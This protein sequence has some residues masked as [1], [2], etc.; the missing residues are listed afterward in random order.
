MNYEYQNVRFGGFGD[1]G[2]TVYTLDLLYWIT[3]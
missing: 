3:K 1:R 2:Y